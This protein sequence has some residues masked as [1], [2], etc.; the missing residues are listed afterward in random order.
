MVIWEMSPSSNY[1]QNKFGFNCI[2]IQIFNPFEK[3]QAT[4]RRNKANVFQT[5]IY[6]ITMSKKTC[7]VR[8]DLWEHNMGA[9]GLS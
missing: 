9:C 1:S 7:M 3:T 8:G 2:E 5:M 6:S 4:R